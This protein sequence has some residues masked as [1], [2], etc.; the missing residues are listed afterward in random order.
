MPGTVWASEASL[1]QHVHAL[2]DENRRLFGDD[3]ALRDELALA[4]GRQRAQPRRATP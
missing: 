2:R 1:R 4:Y 3:A